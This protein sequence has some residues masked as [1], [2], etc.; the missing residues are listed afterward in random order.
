MLFGNGVLCISTNGV[1][2][3]NARNVRHRLRGLAMA[4]SIFL[5]IMLQ[6][7]SPCVGL[8]VPYTPKF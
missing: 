5:A 8:T 2:C 1:L 6:E 7:F 3:S 4:L